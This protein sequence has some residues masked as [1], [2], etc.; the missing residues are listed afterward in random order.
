MDDCSSTS[1]SMLKSPQMMNGRPRTWRSAPTLH[2]MDSLAQ[3]RPSP[4]CRY[5]LTN[6]TPPGQKPE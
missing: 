5:R 2:K 3:D 4:V 1:G 6:V